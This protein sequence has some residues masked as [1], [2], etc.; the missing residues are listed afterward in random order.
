[1]SVLRKI[2]KLFLLCKYKFILGEFGIHSDI[3][4]P[5]RIMGGAGIFVGDH[6]IIRP[7]AY[8]A[9]MP[10]TGHDS[11]LVIQDGSVIGHF[12]HIYC[13]KSVIIEKDVLTADKV[14]IADQT[15]SYQNVGIPVNKQPIIQLNE[16]VI[17]EGS[18]IGE[19]ACIMGCKIGKHC[20]VGANSIVNRDIPDYC[21]VAGAPAKIIKRYNLSKD[22]WERCI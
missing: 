11:K 22:I 13:T 2:R 17:G 10:L 4:K 14:L 19:N 1:M 7:F 9:S 3:T 12:N 6:V 21:V 18:W 20:I 5:L 16:V 8:I 15:H